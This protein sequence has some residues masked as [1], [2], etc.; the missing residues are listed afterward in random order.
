MKSLHVFSGWL[1]KKIGWKTVLAALA[2]FIL[3]MIFVLPNAAESSR[4]ATGTGES[5][6]GS[7]LYSAQTL[8]E[9]AESYGEKGRD[10]YIKA[11]FTFDVIWPLVYLF[12]LA[13]VITFFLRGLKPQLLKSANLLPF[14]G[15]VF[16]FLENISASAVMARF[17]AKTP[18]AAELT[19]VFSFIKW[20][21]IYASFGF[22]FL[23]LVIWLYLKAR[24]KPDA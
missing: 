3:F 17:P 4:A 22:V 19:P 18:V 24:K 12:F 9:I 20:S 13:S 1:Y 16:D 7:Y 23:S 5:P 10:Y 8:Y 21:L 11:R 2:V 14:G 15:A 6:D